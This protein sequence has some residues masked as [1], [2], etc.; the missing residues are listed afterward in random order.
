[1]ESEHELEEATEKAR[2]PF[3]RVVGATMATVAV[4]LALVSVLGQMK[5]TE[6][7]LAQQKASDQWA[8]Y[9]AKSIRRYQSEFAG[10]VLR[11]LPGPAAAAAGKKYDA[12]VERYKSDGEE[13]QRKARELEDESKAEGHRALGLH[14]AEIFLEVAIVFCS[15]TLLTRRRYFWLA[16]VVLTVVG[17]VI[18]LRVFLVH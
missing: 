12:N 16:G 17:A 9:Q 3:D 1:M 13:I 8:Y 14:F 5:T 10:D 15:L 11:V 7:L 6:E 18:A 2:E 4:V